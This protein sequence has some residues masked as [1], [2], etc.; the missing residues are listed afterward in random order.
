MTPGDR[1]T[2]TIFA[3]IP[4]RIHPS[5]ELVWLERVTVHE[6]YSELFTGKFEPPMYAWTDEYVTREERNA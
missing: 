5:G 2:R 1:R 6:S 4:R 3:L